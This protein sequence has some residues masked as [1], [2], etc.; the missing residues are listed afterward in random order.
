M[1]N[2]YV[3]ATIEKNWRSQGFDFL[4][5]KK[6]S[7]GH[8]WGAPTQLIEFPNFLLKLKNQRSGIKTAC[9]FIFERNYDVL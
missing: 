3:K 7:P 5:V 8:F 6:L 2:I 4:S 1:P 9:G